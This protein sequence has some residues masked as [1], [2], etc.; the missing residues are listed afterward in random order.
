MAAHTAIIG[1]IW[2][3]IDSYGI[4]PATIVPESMYRPGGY[5]AHDSYIRAK[6][7]HQ[8]L[9]NAIR[10]IDD[11]AI[12]I[13]AAELM[14]PSHL[15]VLGHAWLASPSLIASYRMLQRFGR[16][17][18]RDLFVELRETPGAVEVAYDTSSLSP[19]PA[20]AADT[21]VG[22]IVRFSRLQYGAAFS[23]LSITLRRPEPAQREIWDEFF[24]VTVEFNAAENLARIDPAQADEILTTAHAELFEQHKDALAVSSARREA[25]DIEARA[26]LAIQQ[27]LPSGAVPEARVASLVDISSRT[28]HRRL[29]E[30]GKSFR[31]LLKDVRMELAARYLIKDRYNATEVAF[32]LGYSDSSA[33]SRAFKS[34]FGVAPSEF[35]KTDI[36]QAVP[37][38]TL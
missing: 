7:Y 31:S 24:G 5:I 22:G 23:P 35:C 12:G 8:L 28:L 6:D 36:A 13:R 20:V 33:F 15:G 19:F 29:S 25:S 2:R 21:Q 38:V 32:L 17:F 34:W 9:T 27:L 14:Q 3:V 1:T 18:F 4:D 26:R 11:D 16:V 30:Q 37:V 10:A